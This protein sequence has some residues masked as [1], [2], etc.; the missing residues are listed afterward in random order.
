[1]FNIC[2]GLWQGAYPG[3]A[4]PPGVTALVN[5]CEEYSPELDHDI[6]CQ[7]YLPICDGPFPGHRWLEM[8]VKIIDALIRGGHVVYLHCHAGVSRSAMV[9]IAYLMEKNGWSFE[10]ARDW[11]GAA[12]E[13]INPNRDFVRG[14]R[15]WNP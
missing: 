12:N 13:G 7:V 1:M 6:A 10:T 4:I 3:E 5:L 14:L 9:A 8:T 15:E 11:V 2:E